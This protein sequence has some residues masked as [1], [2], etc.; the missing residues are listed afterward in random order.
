MRASDGEYRNALQ[1][2]RRANSRH[3]EEG[4]EKTEGEGVSGQEVRGS[5]RCDKENTLRNE[6]VKGLATIQLSQVTAGVDGD[7]LLS[8]DVKRQWT[9][10]AWS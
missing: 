10:T 9:G 5:G 7:G 2:R 6:P 3:G 1:V 4:S 8:D